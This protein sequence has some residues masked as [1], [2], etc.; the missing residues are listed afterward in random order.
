MKKGILTNSGITLMTLIIT[1]IVLL[2]LATT[3]TYSGINA[4][5]STKLTT[6]TAEMK[7]M[8]LNVNNLYQK[9][10][11]NGSVT[12]DG[13]NYSGENIINIGES[14]NN[15]KEQEQERIEE[16]LQETLNIS[17]DG[18]KFYSN[19]L[20]QKLGIEGTKQDFLI[21]ISKRTV[22]SYKGLKYHGKIYYLLEQLP[23]NLYNVEYKNEEIIKK[24]EIQAVKV[25]SF[26]NS[27]WK[28]TVNVK[29]NGYIGKGK[30]QYQKQD[31]YW[32]EIDDSNF[33]VSE[34][35]IYNIK[36]VDSA[37]NESDI[38]TQY[39]Y[40]KSGLVAFYDGINNTGNGHTNTTN[41]WK[42]LSGNN[43]DG[44]M[45][46]FD[47]QNQTINK[48]WQDKS[49]KFNGGYIELPIQDQYNDMVV[50]IV[51]NKLSPNKN[52][53]FCFSSDDNDTQREFSS[54]IPYE[55]GN[56]YFDT[57]YENTNEQE[58]KLE[59]LSLPYNF[60][61]DK[62]YNF[63][64]YKSNLDGQK[65]YINSINEK[66]NNNLKRKVGKINYA[67]IGQSPINNEDDLF[68]ANIYSIRIYNRSLT[69]DEIKTN[70]QIDKLRYGISQ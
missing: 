66:F 48:G 49:L 39:A 54:Y 25:E 47:L 18:F 35:G 29:Y 42:D 10:K 45:H 14:I 8:Q 24:P 4:I 62:I 7:I 21:N 44:V 5:E 43:K 3:A 9:Y 36:V 65:I 52:Y 46:G 15:L 69:D 41:I 26:D 53:V 59:T 64:F 30:I 34:P 60:N 31:G 33:I 32:K 61:N 51:A 23:E 37:N 13:N 11:D 19:D 17:V 28:F 68:L 38:V 12:I 22:V 20:I 27:S 16:I 6:F 2:I 57:S 56:I 58:T 63:T 1:I 67:T 50:E 55:D 70:Y 40:T